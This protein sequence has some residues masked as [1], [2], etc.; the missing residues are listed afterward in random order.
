MVLPGAL[1]VYTLV[2]PTALHADQLVHK[3][4][5]SEL[6]ELTAVG[7]AEQAELMQLDTEAP[8]LAEQ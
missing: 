7:V 1:V 6:Y 8:W 2:E 3:D 5:D 4:A